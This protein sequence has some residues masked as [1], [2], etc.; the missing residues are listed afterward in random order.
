MKTDTVPC[1]ELE[2]ART[3]CSSLLIIK[4][5]GEKPAEEMKQKF[6]IEKLIERL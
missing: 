4:Q 2:E 5:N 6:K 3:V 1:N